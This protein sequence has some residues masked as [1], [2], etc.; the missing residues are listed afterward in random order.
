MILKVAHIFPT[1]SFGGL[2]RHMQA[3][4]RLPHAEFQSVA[5]EIFMLGSESVPLSSQ[6]IGLGEP[7]DHY[8]DVQRLSGKLKKRLQRVRPA[9]VHTYHC[10]ADFYA[11]AAAAELGIPVVRTVAGIS[12]MGW[13]D[14][15]EARTAREDW[16]REEIEIELAL[17]S[18]VSITVAVS[19]EMKR[20]LIGYG[21]PSEKIRVSYLGTDISPP[22]RTEPYLRPRSGDGSLV[23]GFMHRLEPIK[24]SPVLLPVLH[25]LVRAGVDITLV[26]VRG[27]R[28][29]DSFTSSLDE[30]GVRYRLLPQSADIWATVPPLDLV[31]LSSRSEGLPLFPLEAMARGIPVVSTPVGGVPE[32][33][34]HGVTGWL[35]EWHDPDGLERALRTVAENSE[36]SARVCAAA[37]EAVRSRMDGASH[38]RDLGDIYTSLAVS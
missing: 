34:E 28:L 10:F 26:L 30:A 35:F 23:I 27:G 4:E 2:W 32:I 12:Q 20:R 22:S 6:I 11:I 14:N 21:L 5:F 33:I 3:A 38:V 7:P 37:T 16:N 24:L 1:L 8:A 19:D 29:T 31:L 15:F 17:E 25:N 36:A 13:G 18:R 9:V